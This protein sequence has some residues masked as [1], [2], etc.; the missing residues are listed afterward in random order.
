[1]TCKKSDYIVRDK[2]GLK[3]LIY[4]NTVFLCISVI[5]P[6]ALQLCYEIFMHF[7]HISIIFICLLGTFQYSIESDAKQFLFKLLNIN[8][9]Q[10][11]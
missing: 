4:F 9:L 1:M 5:L 10:L 8:T 2:F 7:D 3:Y 11:Q 6:G